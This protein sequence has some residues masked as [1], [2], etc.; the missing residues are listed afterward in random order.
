MER[1][2]ERWRRTGRWTHRK[3]CHHLE[4]LATAVDPCIT[5]MDPHRHLQV[6]VSPRR[7]TIAA[8]CSLSLWTHAA[9]CKSP[10]RH[11][12]ATPHPAAVDPRAPPPW[13]SAE[14][15]V[16][17]RC[18]SPH[19]P[20]VADPCV[21]P[22]WRRSSAGR[23]GGPPP[24][25]ASSRGDGEATR[26]HCWGWS[27]AGTCRLGTVVVVPPTWRRSNATCE[28]RERETSWGRSQTTQSLFYI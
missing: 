12:A 6:P 26:R 22:P 20:V 25:H 28:T 24:R 3:S 13:R 19:C 5:A 18:K 9:A 10:H 11:V 14:D 16:G 15:E 1:G 2:R 7:P 17:R 8:S 4:T 27:H 23:G 21:P